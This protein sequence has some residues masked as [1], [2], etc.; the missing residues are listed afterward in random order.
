MDTGYLGRPVTGHPDG[1]LTRSGGTGLEAWITQIEAD[2]D[3][4]Y[5]FYGSDVD[6]VFFDEGT[7]ACGPDTV[8]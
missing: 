2:V 8:V 4:W 3:A 5:R 6:G 1:L 7:D